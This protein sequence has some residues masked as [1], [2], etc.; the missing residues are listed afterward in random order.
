MTGAAFAAVREPGAG[1]AAWL[2]PLQ[3]ITCLLLL[4][5]RRGAWNKD[6]EF[7]ELAGPGIDL[8]RS[9]VLLDDN[10]VAQ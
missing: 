1:A 4:C 5:P 7:G 9:G 8:D 3:Q 10:I 2:K 6:P